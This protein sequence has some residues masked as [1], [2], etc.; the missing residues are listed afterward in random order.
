MKKI[1]FLFVLSVFLFNSCTVDR[2]IND[3][4]VANPNAQII[5]YWDFNNDVNLLVPTISTG[6]TNINYLGAFFDSVEG[7]TLNTR[8]NSESGTALR[9]RNPAGDLVVAMPTLGYKDVTLSYAAMRTGS[10]AQ[11]Q[12]LQYT[13]DGVNYTSEGVLN[14]EVAITEI[15]VL[16]QFDLSAIPNV[17]NNANF[18]VKISFSNGAENLTGN[19]R[20]DNLVLEGVPSGDPIP[21]P[22]AVFLVHYWNF[23]T[24]PTGTLSNPIAADFSLNGTN[25][26]IAYLGTGAGYADQFSPGSDLNARNGDVAGL[27]VRFRNPSNTRDVIFSIP[28]NG[29]KDLVFKFATYRTNTGPQTQNY[30]YSIDGTNFI[31]TGLASTSFEAPLE[32]NFEV[33]TIDFIG[34]NTVNNNSNFKV[35]ISFTG[36]QAGGTSGNSRFDNITLEGKTN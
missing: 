8:Q 23:N 6:G 3:V 9:L 35:K 24:L 2:E 11:I 7:T 25:A 28:S 1:Y 34:I 14:S 22:N 29:Y 19:N 36:T 31:T 27:G 33:V 13:T 32:P 30:S 5:H 16:K 18:K 21:D 17:T 26:S 15:Y 4:V 10:G 12:T 20:I